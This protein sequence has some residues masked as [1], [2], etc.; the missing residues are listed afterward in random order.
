MKVNPCKIDK[1]KIYR[2]SS[3]RCCHITVH[4]EGGSGPAVRKNWIN[5]IYCVTGFEDVIAI[6]EPS[7]VTAFS[8][9]L[10]TII[11]DALSLTVRYLTLFTSAAFVIR[12]TSEVIVT[13]DA[14]F[15]AR[16]VNKRSIVLSNNQN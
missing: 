13:A 8:N 7:R 16:R 1:R 2:P 6:S 11:T 3:S 14:E 5:T 9:S 4:V 12:V 15:G 10:M